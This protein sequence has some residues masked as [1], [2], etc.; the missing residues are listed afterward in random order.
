MVDIS[1]RSGAKPFET[2]HLDFEP[3]GFDGWSV[4][5]L[6]AE[7]PAVIQSEVVRQGKRACRFEL[8][9][10]DYVSQGHRAEL[11]DPY[12]A[13]W[14]EQVW[15]GFSTRLADDFA[16]PDNIGCVFPQW[17]DQAKLGHP[18]GKPPIAIRYRAGR[19]F[20]TGAYGR[21]ASPE[22]DIRYEFACVAD[23]AAGVW[24]DVIV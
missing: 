20:I 18:S 3:G 17:H 9:P 1:S 8:R 15:Y 6:S 22:P 14:D 24:H 13:M 19:L 23:V 11:R 4:K 7:H 10:G 16:L 12:N 2:V 5:L 21:T